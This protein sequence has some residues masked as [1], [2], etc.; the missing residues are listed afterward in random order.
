MIYNPTPFSLNILNGLF[1]TLL[2]Y[3]SFILATLFQSDTIHPLFPPELWKHFQ[4]L[5]DTP[6]GSYH[7]QTL[8]QKIVDFGKSLHLDT[9]LLQCG[10]VLIPATNGKENSPTVC[11]QAHLDMVTVK[12]NDYTID[13]EKDSRKPIIVEDPNEGP[14]LMSE[15]TSLGAD[16]GVGIVLLMALLES[17]DIPHGPLECLFTMDEVFN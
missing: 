1:L 9:E 10:N 11:V 7:T 12:D 3:S 2:T 8:A 14:L 13:L 16:N 17:T 15:G 4:L 5:M 6:H